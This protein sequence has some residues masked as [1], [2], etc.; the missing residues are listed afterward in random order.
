[1]QTILLPGL[2]G[3]LGASSTCYEIVRPSIFLLVR[4]SFILSRLNY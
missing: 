3:L 4:L 1:M 2:R